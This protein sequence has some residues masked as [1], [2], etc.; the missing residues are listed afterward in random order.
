MEKSNNLLL[1]CLNFTFKSDCRSFLNNNMYLKNNNS[2]PHISDQDVA[3]TN[4]LIDSIH[5][6]QN[7]HFIPNFDSHEFADYAHGFS[8]I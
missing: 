6:N 1:Q 7:T 5:F 4:M 3:I 8:C 2:S